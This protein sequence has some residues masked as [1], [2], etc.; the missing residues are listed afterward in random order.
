MAA[1]T[2]G[3]GGGR[4]I[5]KHLIPNTMGPIII[6]LTFSIPSAIFTEATLSYLSLGVP[7]ASGQLGHA[8]PTRAPVSCS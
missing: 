5:R 6:E 1:R 8:L 4:I 7:G 3:A 2:L